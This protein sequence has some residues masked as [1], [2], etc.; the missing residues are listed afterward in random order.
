MHDAAYYRARAIQCLEVARS[1][2]DQKG[3]KEMSVMA[4]HYLTRAAEIEA[5]GSITQRKHDGATSVDGV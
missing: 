1:I 2:S 4:L 3:V 5:Q